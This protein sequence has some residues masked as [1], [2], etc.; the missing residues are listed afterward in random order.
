MDPQGTVLA[1]VRAILEARRGVIAAAGGTALSTQQCYLVE[2]PSSDGGG[3]GDGGRVGDGG[4]GVAA[5]AAVSEGPPLLSMTVYAVPFGDQLI[6]HAKVKGQSTT[7]KLRL[8]VGKYAGKGL[9]AGEAGYESLRMRVETRLLFAAAPHLRG[10]VEP[11]IG[12]T[13]I[14]AVLTC[15]CLRYLGA[16]SL[17]AFGGT[18]RPNRSMVNA[19]QHTPLRPA[20]GTPAATPNAPVDMWDALFVLEFNQPSPTTAAEDRDP[21]QVFVEAWVNRRD[22]RRRRE[23]ARRMYEYQREQVREQ[24]QEYMRQSIRH[25]PR[26]PPFVDPPLRPPGDPL[27]PFNPELELIPGTG[28]PQHPYPGLPTWGNVGN[29]A[30]DAA[31]RDTGY[32]DYHDIGPPGVQGPPPPYGAPPADVRQ[33]GPWSGP[34]GIR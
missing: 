17:V 1:A 12:R 28:M 13:G 34:S 24:E 15:R 5:A 31:M 18:S 32:G 11:E 6:L 10:S 29:P 22:R 23:F 21:R 20:D 7:H 27:H 30:R 9:L 4:D 26:F 19:P 33:M 8:I 2:P 14:G 3:G 25:D 16:P